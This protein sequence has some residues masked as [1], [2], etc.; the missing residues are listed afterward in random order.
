MKSPWILL[1][2]SEF[3]TI[4]TVALASSDAACPSA[5]GGEDLK[6]QRREVY[7][8][9]RIFDISHRLRPDMPAWGSKDGLGQFLWLSESMK[10]G[11]YTN[12]SEMK[13]PIHTGTHVDAPGHVSDRYFDAGFD[14]DSLD[15]GLLNG[16]ALLVDVPRDENITDVLLLSTVLLVLVCSNS[17]VYGHSRHPEKLIELYEIIGDIGRDSL[18]R[19]K[20]KNPKGNIWFMRR[21]MW[22]KEFDTSYVGF[23]KDGAQWLVENT[24]IKLVGVDY[25]T[26]AAYTDLLSPHLVFLEGRRG[27]YAEGAGRFRNEGD[28]PRVC[29]KTLE[30]G[31]RVRSGLEDSGMWK[32]LGVSRR[33][34]MGLEHPRLSWRSLPCTTLVELQKSYEAFSGG[35]S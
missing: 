8:G 9:G 33:V 31:R 12:N 1:T 11:S 16:P 23:T 17:S 19:L 5:N 10:N 30:C 28:Q 26:V 3:L 15:L 21:L 4:L 14:A 22:K 18:F 6:P 2:C 32:N 7:D 27:Q 24:D 35:T 20:F 34:W 29:W 13:L 25:L